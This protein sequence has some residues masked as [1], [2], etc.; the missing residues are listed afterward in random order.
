MEK[1]AGHVLKSDKVKLQG[2]LQLDFMQPGLHQPKTKTV[3]SAAPQARI[4][5]NNP[6][7]VVIE[8]TC[9]CGTRTQLKCNHAAAQAQT[10]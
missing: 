7:F 1:T 2:R 10:K 3:V 9:P 4:V 5:E 6:E 8:V